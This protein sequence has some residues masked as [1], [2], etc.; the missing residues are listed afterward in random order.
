MGQSDNP[1]IKAVKLYCARCEDIYNPKSSRHSAIDGAYF[2]TSFH[3][4]IF[5]VYPALI[6]IKSYERYTPRIYGFKV[7]AP[8]SLIRWQ[9]SERD[10]MRK[11]LRKL[12]IESGFKDDEEDVDAE[13]SEEEDDD[14]E[15][16]MEAIENGTVETGAVTKNEV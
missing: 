4:I 3:N 12:E 2:G 16:E 6:P 11:R 13:D 15:V 1:N 7:H 9:H 5:Q 8:A 14:E 10:E